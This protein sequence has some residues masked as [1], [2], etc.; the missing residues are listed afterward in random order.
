MDRN[1]GGSIDEEY[2]SCNKN[3]RTL[4]SIG[5]EKNM[6]NY[7]GIVFLTRVERFLRIVCLSSLLALA[8]RIYS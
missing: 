5:K 4:Q 1:D 3:K 8:S 2:G 7:P 6:V